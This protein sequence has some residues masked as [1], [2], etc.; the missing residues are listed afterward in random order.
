VTAVRRHDRDE[1]AATIA[2][3]YLDVYR[4]DDEDDEPS[5]ADCGDTIELG[6]QWAYEPADSTTFS[7]RR[8]V[9][10]VHAGCAVANGYRLR[11][12]EDAERSD[13][14]IRRLSLAE[15]AVA[16]IVVEYEQRAC[17]GDVIE[18]AMRVVPLDYEEA[19][20][21]VVDYGATS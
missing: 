1:P 13:E 17:I 21:I 11:W 15:A 16:R 20:G 4:W 18:W 6:Q 3:Q 10:T 8:V 9:L 7:G 19:R 2:S 12:P 14:L 5:C